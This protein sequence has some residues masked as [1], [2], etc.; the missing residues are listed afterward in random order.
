[1]RNEN[2]IA[3]R[4]AAERINATRQHWEGVGLLAVENLETG[5]CGLVLVPRDAP[6]PDWADEI[7]AGVPGWETDE[8]ALLT[9]LGSKWYR[10]LAAQPDTRWSEFANL[11]NLHVP[12]A[13]VDAMPAATRNLACGH[14]FGVHALPPVQ[15]THGLLGRMVAWLVPWQQVPAGDGRQA[16]GH[17][18]GRSGVL[19]NWAMGA[20][21]GAA[22]R[23]R[24]ERLAAGGMMEWGVLVAWPSAVDAVVAFLLAQADVLDAM[25][26]TQVADAP[27]VQK[28]TA[29]KSLNQARRRLVALAV[30]AGRVPAVAATEVQAHQC[31]SALKWIQ[32]HGKDH[33]PAD[34]LRALQ[35]EGLPPEWL[36]LAAQQFPAG[37]AL[38]DLAAPLAHLTAKQFRAD[39]TKALAEGALLRCS[40]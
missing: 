26:G 12:A 10:H 6:Q 32:G 1:M 28:R 18:L 38:A 21:H 24:D 40:K 23:T 13:L 29:P 22:G 8:A 36:D 15:N 34:E 9:Q 37:C 3:L 7:I 33:V 31:A 14:G 16:C 30:V 39:I 2:S 4:T 19:R 25:P 20:A 5:A 17:W 11:L 27:P 35:F